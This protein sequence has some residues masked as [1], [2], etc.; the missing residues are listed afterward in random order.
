VRFGDTNGFWELNPF[1]GC[2]QLIVSNHAFIYPAKR[3]KG[4]GKNQHIARLS[5]ASSQ[6]YDYIMCTVNAD[7]KAEIAILEKFHW[8]KLDGFVNGQTGNLVFV[9]G[10]RLNPPHHTDAQASDQGSK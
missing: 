9:Y 2:N 8:K 1:P 4:L 5:Y 3:G 6:G 7:N 10:R